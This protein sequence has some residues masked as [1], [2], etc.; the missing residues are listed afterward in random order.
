MTLADHPG[1]STHS[2]G[3]G[4]SRRVVVSPRQAQRFG[5]YGSR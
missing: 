2:V 1:V 5:G 4:D 3:E